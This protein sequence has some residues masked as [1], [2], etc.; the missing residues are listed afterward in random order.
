[1]HRTKNSP[2]GEV[3]A[4]RASNHESVALHLEQLYQAKQ[5][6]DRHCPACPG[7][8]WVSDCGEMDYPDKP[9]ND[10]WGS[11]GA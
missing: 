6:I 3:G 1:M 7:N 2:H 11:W 4:Q 10:G 9:G 8:P 5:P